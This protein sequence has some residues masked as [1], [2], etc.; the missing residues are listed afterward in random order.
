MH[1]ICWRPTVSTQ[2]RQQ[3]PLCYHRLSTAAAPTLVLLV[4]ACHCNQSD[5][6]PISLHHVAAPTTDVAAKGAEKRAAVDAALAAAPRSIQGARYAIGSQQH[7]YMEPQVSD[8]IARLHRTAG[9]E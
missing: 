9:K 3:S 7:F 1:H 5:A 4:A 6:R 8:T 2:L